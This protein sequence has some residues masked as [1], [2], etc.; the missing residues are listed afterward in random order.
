MNSASINANWVSFR[1]M[2]KQ[3]LLLMWRYP[4]NMIANFLLVLVMVIV[5]TLLTTIFSPPGTE[6]RLKGLTLYGFIIYLFLSHTLWNTGMGIHKEK[7]AGTLSSFYLSAAPRFLNLWARAAAT[8]LWTSVAGVLGLLVAQMITG[9]LTAQQPW[10]ALGVL[11]FTVSGLLGLG[12]AVAGLALLFGESVE[13]V[14]NVLEFGLMGICALFYPFSIL[15][16]PLL[17]LAKFIPLSYGVDAFRTV[18]MGALQP[19]LLPLKAELIIVA[20]SGL[21]SPLAGYLFFRYC[22]LKVRK[23]GML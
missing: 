19:E 2:L 10:L 5:V 1:A 18:A 6:S 13:I 20:V 22:E 17:T 16:A 23:S 8:L 21:L 9:P 14:S 15:P 3:Q 4:A 12:F 7:M 11:F